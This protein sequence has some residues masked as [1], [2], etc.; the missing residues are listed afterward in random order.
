[1]TVMSP[2]SLLMIAIAA[3]TALAALNPRVL[4]SKRWRATVTPLASIIGSGFLVVVPILAHAAGNW[5][6]LAM[7]ALC[8]AAYMFGAVVRH[9]IAVVEPLLENGAPR[10]LRLLEGFSNLALTFAYFVSVAYYLNL[11]AAFGLRS[12]DITDPAWVRIASTGV[13]ALI[14]LAFAGI[15]ATGL[16]AD[17]ATFCTPS[18][19]ASAREEIERIEAALAELPERQRVAVSMVRMLG[20]SYPEAA[21]ALENAETPVLTVDLASQQVSL[22]QGR[23]WSFEI[24][25]DARESLL[26]GLDPIDQTLLLKPAIEGFRLDDRQRRPWVYSSVDR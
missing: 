17:Y 26:N 1:M 18:R 23:A 9:N 4:R 2:T 10:S 21:E 20:L 12:F 24:R 14:G 5:A 3:V 22:P 16:L 11:F 15:A 13:I 8:A 7:T 6:W 19:V 25:P